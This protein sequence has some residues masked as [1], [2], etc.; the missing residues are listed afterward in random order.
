MRARETLSGPRGEKERVDG[1]KEREQEIETKREREEERRVYACQKSDKRK[2]WRKRCQGCV[3]RQCCSGVGLWKALYGVMAG[4]GP[5]LGKYEDS[6]SIAE[7]RWTVL[8]ERVKGAGMELIVLPR[9]S[10]IKLTHRQAQCGTAQ[11]RA[12]SL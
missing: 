1:E 11:Y 2:R 4:L 7:E 10:L 5:G 3:P 6:K 8:T 12:I 9:C